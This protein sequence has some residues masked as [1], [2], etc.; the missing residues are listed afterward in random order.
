MEILRKEIPLLSKLL[1]DNSGLSKDMMYRIKE[2]SHLHGFDIE[3][4]RNELHLQQSRNHATKYS[5]VNPD[6]LEFDSK[7]I[8]A[9]EGLTGLKDSTDSQTED[10][11]ATEFSNSKSND[12]EVN[13][14]KDIE[15]QNLDEFPLLDK[16]ST[17]H[18]TEFSNVSG[19]AATK[20]GN[21]VNPMKITNR[22]ANLANSTY[23]SSKNLNKSDQNPYFPKWAGSDEGH[24][25]L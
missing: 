17:T 5:N 24:I 16:D 22:P 11:D 8:A 19:D 10:G 2:A 9:I 7:K 6:I 23:K 4:S 14:G 25:C 18:A 12:I 3:S 13:T 20:N 1:H 15:S 21:F